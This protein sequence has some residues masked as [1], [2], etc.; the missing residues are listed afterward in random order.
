MYKPGHKTYLQGK[1]KKTNKEEKKRK[2]TFGKKTET[3]TQ[4]WGE[5][6]TYIVFKLNGIN[7]LP[8][9]CRSQC[10]ING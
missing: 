4:R 1:S 10:L 2:K 9:K 7:S 8:H 5:G 6:D 3:G